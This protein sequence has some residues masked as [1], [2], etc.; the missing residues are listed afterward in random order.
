[1][2][3][4]TEPAPAADNTVKITLP[5]DGLMKLD[6]DTYQWGKLKGKQRYTFT[7]GALAN[8]DAIKSAPS[9]DEPPSWGWTMGTIRSS[10]HF[11]LAPAPEELICKDF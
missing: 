3:S 8:A 2:S 5:A 11:E 10:S 6:E 9:P 1:M 7:L 4:G